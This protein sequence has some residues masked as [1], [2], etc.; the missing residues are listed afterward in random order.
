[1]KVIFV[2]GAW[3]SGTSAVMGALDPLG[4]ATFG[5]HAQSTDTRTPGTFELIPFRK[6]ILDFIDEASMSPRDD[7]GN[8][9][10]FW[11][12]IASALRELGKRIECGEFGV[13][14]GGMPK[15]LA[16]KMPLASLCLTAIV[17]AFDADIVLIHRPLNE[18]EASRVRRRWPE[19]FGAKGANRLYSKLFTDIIGQKAHGASA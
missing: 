8:E 4:V 7:Y 9:I 13:W 15:V 14:P 10:D 2:A 16:L 18:I 1:M 3:G 6:I 5:P 11:A 19:Q 12:Q 17:R